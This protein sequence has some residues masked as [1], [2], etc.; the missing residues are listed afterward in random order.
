MKNT[1]NTAK[2][3]L[4]LCA[5]KLD[6]RRLNTSMTHLV[7][8]NKTVD[9][10]AAKQLITKKDGLAKRISDLEARINPNGIA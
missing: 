7:K 8:Q 6:Q 5:M 3:Q 2:Q 4:L 10:F 1:D 9:F